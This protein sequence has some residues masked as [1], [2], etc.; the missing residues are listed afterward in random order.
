MRCCD[1]LWA[2]LRWLFVA[3]VFQ[4]VIVWMEWAL[5]AQ[6]ATLFGSALTDF[7]LSLPIVV[8]YSKV[9][10]SKADFSVG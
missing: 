4:L 5:G 10:Y 1:V 6:W 7:C 3:F 2:V 9:Q 8:Q